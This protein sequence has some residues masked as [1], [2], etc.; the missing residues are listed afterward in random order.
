[1]RMP[2]LPETCALRRMVLRSG[3]LK[4]D[5]PTRPIFLNASRLGASTD[6]RSQIFWME[7][8]RRTR[9]D[10]SLRY[11]MLLRLGRR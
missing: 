4:F 3:R 2:C 8:T 7:Q 5:A 9:G 11:N 6:F 1:M 10:Y